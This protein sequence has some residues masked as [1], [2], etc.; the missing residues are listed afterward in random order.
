MAEELHFSRAA[1]RVNLAQSAVSAHVRQ[2]EQEVGGAL[3]TRTSRRVE[4]TP[5]GGALLEDART[6]LEIAESALARARGL[7]RGETGSL[8]VGCFGP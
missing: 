4:L 6:M 2:L 1:H 5:A 7:A 3:L 8:V